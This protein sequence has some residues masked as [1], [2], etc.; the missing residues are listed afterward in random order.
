[1]TYPV[2][3]H[4]FT[5]LKRIPVSELTPRLDLSFVEVSGTGEKPIRQPRTLNETDY[6]TI[7]YTDYT[8]G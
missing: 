8:L 3:L 4:L 2:S 7:V 1:M 5:F 6:F